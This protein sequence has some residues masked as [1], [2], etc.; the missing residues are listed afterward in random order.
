MSK[1]KRL[2]DA[3]GFSG[4][5]PLQIVKGIFGDPKARVII[6]KRR[7]KKQ[8]VP[9]VARRTGVFMIAKSAVCAISPVAI[10]GYFWNWKYAAS[11]AGVAAR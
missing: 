1:D 5:V 3:Y 7:T 11:N 10:H 6:L 9:H 8:F 4:F 2:S